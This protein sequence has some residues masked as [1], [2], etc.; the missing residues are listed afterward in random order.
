MSDTA[1]KRALQAA[2]RSDCICYGECFETRHGMMHGPCE[3]DLA[4]AAAAIAAFL[5]ALPV[6]RG[7]G[8]DG[9]VPISLRP[10]AAEVRRAGG[11]VG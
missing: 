6:L 9:A 11:G 5:E 3:A 2:A 7:D 10:M 1:I 8:P 4:S